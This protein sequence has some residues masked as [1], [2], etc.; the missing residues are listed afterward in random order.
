[1]HLYGILCGLVFEWV[2]IIFCTELVDT[3]DIII[4]KNNTLFKGV[5]LEQMLKVLYI[6]LNNQYSKGSYFF[7]KPIFCLKWFVDNLNT[8]L[9]Q[10]NLVRLMWAYFIWQEFVFGFEILGSGSRNRNF[11]SES[12]SSSKSIQIIF[13]STTPILHIYTDILYLSSQQMMMMYWWFQHS[14]QKDVY[15]NKIGNTHTYI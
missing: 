6:R 5:F 7:P 8:N 14:F 12:F 2:E 1:M 10:F 9:S 11:I 4:I 3:L 15:Y 13:Y